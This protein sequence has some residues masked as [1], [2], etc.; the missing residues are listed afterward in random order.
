MRQQKLIIEEQTRQLKQQEVQLRRLDGVLPPTND[1]GTSTDPAVLALPQDAGAGAGL[2][3][4]PE[5]APHPA[6]GATLASGGARKSFPPIRALMRSS[7]SSPRRREHA[8]SQSEG[9]SGA[10]HHRADA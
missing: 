6:A 4:R 8:R 9:Q 2:A 5:C 3:F 7:L 1:K 10:P